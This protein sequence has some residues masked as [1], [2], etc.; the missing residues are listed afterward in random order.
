MTGFPQEATAAD[1]TVVALPNAG[2]QVFV[3]TVP[4]EGGTATIYTQSFLAHD[5]R[6]RSPIQTLPDGEFVYWAWSDWKRLR[7]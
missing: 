4:P 3:A 1:L 6:T 2:I 5:V 7:T